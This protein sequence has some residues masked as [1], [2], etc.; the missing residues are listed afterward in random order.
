MTDVEKVDIHP[1]SP[2]M[3]QM[4]EMLMEVVHRI[5][6][7][8]P[9]AMGMD[10]DDKAGIISMMR[11]A[12]TSRN[13]QR[14]FDQFDESQRICGDIMIEMVQK[15]WTYG[16]VKQV[17]GE[18]PTAEF[19][20]KAF[21]KYG[22]KIIQG[23]LTESQQ[24]LE[25]AQLL[26]LQ[27]I[28][29]ETMKGV[30]MEEIVETMTIQNKDRIL[31]KYAK[32]QESQAKQADEMHQLQMQQ[33]QVENATK[34]AYAHSQ[35]GLAKERVAKIQLDKALNAE[36]IQR[37]EEDKTAGVLNLVKA[38]KELQ[39]ID[40]NHLSQYLEIVEKL[41]GEEEANAESTAD[42]PIKQ[43]VSYGQNE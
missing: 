6:G 37:A 18:E 21:F 9:A 40:L 28:V 2:V 32:A 23:V 13:L 26:H 15:N 33:L 29:P 14:L 19:D 16:K 27:S 4:E 10:V 20:N 1:P 38:F 5:A 3:L 30:M 42:K 25:L 39:S 31:E 11:H 24:Q 43:E 36:R 8:D 7:V 41:K 34:I 22:C 17:I 35:E 12:A